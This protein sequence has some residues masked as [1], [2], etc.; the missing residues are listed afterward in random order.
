MMP[1]HPFLVDGAGR[2]A[3]LRGGYRDAD[4][5]VLAGPT[6]NAH[7][8][9]RLL[10]PCRIVPDPTSPLVVHSMG[11]GLPNTVKRPP[12]EVWVVLTGARE[13]IG[14]AAL[15]GVTV[16]THVRLEYDRG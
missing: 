1:S 11:V 9:T 13:D 16:Y 10:T 14:K 2:P 3:W 4:V 5:I 6:P 12:G 7:Y 8:G 15:G